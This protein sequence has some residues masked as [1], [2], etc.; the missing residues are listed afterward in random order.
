[1]DK[2]DPRRVEQ[3]RRQRATMQLPGLD[4]MQREANCSADVDVGDGGLRGRSRKR[5][6]P[7]GSTPGS[8]SAGFATRRRRL[9]R[10]DEGV[11]RELRRSVAVHQP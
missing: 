1:V 8:R 10:N 2:V 5:H 3:I 9:G 7:T 11:T 4:H 6:P